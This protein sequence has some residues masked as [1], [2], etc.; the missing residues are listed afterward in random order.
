MLL[1][2]STDAANSTETI[3][4]FAASNTNSEM[5]KEIA[6]KLDQRSRVN[7]C[8]LDLGRKFD[9][10]GEKLKEIECGQ[11]N[12]TEALIEYLYSKEEDLLT[13]RRFYEEVQQLKRRDVL[14][15]L[16][17]FFDG[18]FYLCSHHL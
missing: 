4:D 12:P 6:T 5:I 10:S 13:V 14:K 16:Q 11:F 17:R 1:F 8:W 7:A 18:E 15:I 2:L 9:I 3:S